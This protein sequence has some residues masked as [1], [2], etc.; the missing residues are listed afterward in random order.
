[1]YL[2]GYRKWR[3]LIVVCS[4]IYLTV[5]VLFIVV[6]STPMPQGVGIFYTM[7]GYILNFLQ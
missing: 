2:L 6:M 3:R 1:M 7:N 5:V 4:C